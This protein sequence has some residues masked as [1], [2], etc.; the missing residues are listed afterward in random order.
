MKIVTFG[1]KQS[2]KTNILS[3]L[4]YDDFTGVYKETV[5]IDFFIKNFTL[6]EK[7]IKLQF[8]DIE[9]TPKSEGEK[10]R[11]MCCRGV[12]GLIVVYS[13]VD[14]SSFDFAQQLLSTGLNKDHF[15]NDVVKFLIANKSDLGLEAKV[16][17]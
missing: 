6:A 14:S 1:A 12:I 3:R 10:V 8:W 17:K 11:E 13:I 7:K 16:G 4:C 15:G 5:G 9:V 2:G